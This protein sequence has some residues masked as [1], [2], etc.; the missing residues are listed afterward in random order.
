MSG[1]K[2]FYRNVTFSKS[3]GK[4]FLIDI[5]DPEGDKEELDGWFGLVLLMA[6]G[7][8]TVDELFN[9]LSTK[10]QGSP[11]DNLRD[12]I[13]SVIQRMSETKFI[14]LTDIKTE[15]PYY[16]SLPYEQLDVDKAIGLMEQDRKNVN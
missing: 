1:A 14:V 11:P 7:Q 8:H 15:L 3:N 4:V 13:D 6:D 9:F 10:Y 2:Y 16:L 12:T 5:A